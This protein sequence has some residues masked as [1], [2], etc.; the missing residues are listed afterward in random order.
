MTL[1]LTETQFET[2][3]TITGHI[4][5]PILLSYIDMCIKI[6]SSDSCQIYIFMYHEDYIHEFH[7]LCSW[8]WFHK[9]R[10]NPG[11][12]QAAR[13]LKTF[14]LVFPVPALV[15]FQQ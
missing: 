7:C 1:N 11:M 14:S 15:L 5:S 3:H 12:Q 2:R 8:I 4:F 10:G 9:L 6:R 13:K